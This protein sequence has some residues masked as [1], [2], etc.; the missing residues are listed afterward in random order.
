MKK[1]LIGLAMILT[2]HVTNAAERPFRI[3]REASNVNGHAIAWGVPGKTFDFEKLDTM[4]D[5]EIEKTIDLDAVRN[6]IVDIQTN[7][8]L[9]VLTNESNMAVFNIGNFHYGNHFD[10][11]L[12]SLT[13]EKLD[14]NLQVITLTEYYKWSSDVSKIF[15]I[16]SMKPVVK[17]SEL[18]ASETM[19]LLKKKLRLSILKDNL[20][21]FDT[22]A[23]NSN[24]ITSKYVE[25]IGNLNVFSFDYSY[26][27]QD[28]NSL[29]VVATVKMKME[30]GKIIPYI[31]EV[32]QNQY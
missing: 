31:L 22:A 19:G 25:K 23:E 16:D 28:T 7:Q 6:Y 11:G 3:D 21:L 14:Y 18:D 2:A 30:N 27:K 9:A 15:V 17:I 26:P 32:K 4:T 10:L 8:I 1:L 12:H 5:E 29:K 20:E 13:I 24:G